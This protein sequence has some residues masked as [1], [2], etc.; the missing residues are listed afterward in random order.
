MVAGSVTPMSHEIRRRNI[1]VGG[2]A[3]GDSLHHGK[4]VLA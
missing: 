4:R 2:D 1:V 3:L